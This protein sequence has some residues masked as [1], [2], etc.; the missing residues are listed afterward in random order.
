MRKTLP[1]P[2]HS[3]DSTTPSRP[4]DDATT[5]STVGGEMPPPIDLQLGAEGRL[6]RPVNPAGSLPVEND[7]IDEGLQGL[8]THSE[9]SQ[10]PL[11][12]KAFMVAVGT[13]DPV[14][15]Q[16]EPSLMP[17]AYS[18]MGVNAIEEDAALD[19]LRPPSDRPYLRDSFATNP[20]TSE[21]RIVAHL[22]PDDAD[23]EARIAERLK[24]D[25]TLQVEEQLRQQMV[26]ATEVKATSMCCGLQRR[27]LCLLLASAGCAV[28]GIVIV[29]WWFGQKDDLTPSPT[30]T[31]SVIHQLDPLV[32]ELRLWI[33]PTEDDRLAFTDPT[34]P[35]SRAVDWLRNDPITMSE[36]RST[37]T[38]LERYVLA[39]LYY[40]TSGDNWF[41]PVDFLS[42]AD[43]CSWN[44][45]FDYTVNWSEFGVYC[46]TDGKTVDLLILSSNNLRG[47]LPWELFLLTNLQQVYL[48]FNRLE[49]T[50][51]TRIGELSKLEIIVALSNDLTGPLPTTF[52]SEMLQVD[53]RENALTGTIPSSWATSMPHLQVVSISTNLL[54]GTIPS[55]LGRIA[56][57]TNVSFWGNSLT[58]SV[59]FFCEG[60]ELEVLE[61]DCQEVECSCCTTCCYDDKAMCEK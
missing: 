48:D 61:A 47:S 27:T 12:V 14:N 56:S 35:Q 50:I 29:S 22:A 60:N 15:L 17:G 19:N 3:D 41:Y 18:V 54:T 33:A 24:N 16:A 10:S 55:E 46:L 21:P 49:G 51:P 43:I 36:G 58:G 4:T 30:S 6:R 59:D 31:P 37:G 7:D 23:L 5:S 25:I 57:L 8:Q 44:E 26:L 52:S 39:V 11:H 45:G 53:L 34:S 20:K 38:V 42:D 2:Q 32:E 40:A 13:Q 1:I 28:L 9:E